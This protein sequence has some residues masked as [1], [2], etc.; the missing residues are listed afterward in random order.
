MNSRA[1]FRSLLAAT[2]MLAALTSAYTCACQLPPPAITQVLLLTATSTLPASAQVTAARDSPV[3]RPLTTRPVLPAGRAPTDAS[4]TPR[5]PP[6]PLRFKVGVTGPLV[7]HYVGT[8]GGQPVSVELRWVRPDSASGTC[9]LWQG[10]SEYRLE[11]IHRRKPMVLALSQEV[12][13]I[14]RPR[15]TWHLAGPLG[16]TLRGQ[17]LDAAGRA[18]S[19]RLR[20]NYRQAVP[21]D[22]Q[23]LTLTGRKVADAGCRT[24][25]T[26]CDYL[27]LRGTLRPAW[28]RVQAPGLA[29]RKRRLLATAEQAGETS[30]FLTVRLNDFQLL[31]YQTFYEFYPWDGGRQNELE[32]ALFDLTTGRALSLVSQLQPTYKP[33]LR[34]LLLQHLQQDLAQPRSALTGPSRS[35][36]ANEPTAEAVLANL[37]LTGAGI[38]AS[39]FPAE[40]ADVVGPAIEVRSI[41][42][43]V[44]VPYTELRPLVRPGTPLAHM[45]QLRGLW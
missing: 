7:R 24:P 36:T 10:G 33:P 26:T 9:Y 6:S 3:S 20:E 12:A 39:Y 37:V 18:R 8:V 28:Q 32:S 22:I 2:V 21:Y 4:L 23:A 34:R 19:F 35:P 44:L 1:H 41:P 17:W 38:E 25:S 13:D 43:S 45:L 40:L 14:A 31:S 15:G 30:Y 42:Y 29:T 5:C 16:P 27:H 11:T